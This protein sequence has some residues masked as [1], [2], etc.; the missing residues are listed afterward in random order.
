MPTRVYHVNDAPHDAVCCGRGRGG[1]C[2]LDGQEPRIAPG[3][4]GFFGN[5]HA[6]GVCMYCTS[7]RPVHHVRGEAA[8]LFRS[9]FAKAMREDPVYRKAVDGLRGRPLSCHCPPGGVCHAQSIA[10]YLNTGEVP[11]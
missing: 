1:R 2:Y 7:D 6:V 9:M 8:A 4:Y 11:P 3:T 10:N 5:P